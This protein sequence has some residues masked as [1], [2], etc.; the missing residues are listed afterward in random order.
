MTWCYMLDAY[1]P[2]HFTLY[3]HTYTHTHRGSH[4]DAARIEN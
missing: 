2:K 4:G 1:M 3:T